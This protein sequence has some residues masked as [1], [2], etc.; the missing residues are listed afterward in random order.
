MDEAVR[1]GAALGLRRLRSAEYVGPERPR[2]P[3][4]A[5][6]RRVRLRHGPC[7]RLAARLVGAD[8]ATLMNIFNNPG[9][10]GGSTTDYSYAIEQLQAQHPECATVSLVCAWFFNSEDASNCQIYPS[11][12]FL[13]GEFAQNIGGTWVT[14]INWMVSSLTQAD[15]PGISRF[16]I[17]PGTTNFVYGGTP[18]DQA[19]VRCIRDLKSRGFKV[20]FYP[21]LLGTGDGYPWR[22]RITYSTDLSSAATA[23]VAAFMG[24][25]AVARVH[26]GRGQSD[27]G[28]FG[29]PVRLDLSPDDPALRE[30][31][32][33]RRRRESIRHRLGTAGGWR[34]C[35]G[36]TGRQTARPTAPEMRFGTIRS[37]RR[38]KRSPTTCARCSTISAT[39]ENLAGLAEPHRL[40][41]R[42]VELDGLAASG[43]ER[44]M[45]AS[46]P[47]LGALE[48]RLRLV[49]QLSA[50]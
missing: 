17:C 26:A 21:F 30:L 34:S 14:G 48:H 23:A 10:V 27:G 29:Q 4:A 39:A 9:G 20:I 49:R 19:I 38:C 25:A 37:S 7:R 41:G 28:L 13:L 16:R 42:L 11:T 24:S 12:N 50:A 5:V 3:S 35:A 40:F 33:R 36:R 47:A 46:R 2:R 45:A 6:D 15:Y 32:H 1:H 43:R 8:N 31:L 18:S 22:G 44:P